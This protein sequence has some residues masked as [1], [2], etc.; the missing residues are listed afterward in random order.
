MPESARPKRL[1]QGHDWFTYRW[2]VAQAF[3]TIDRLQDLCLC[4]IGGPS[5]DSREDS[6][7]LMSSLALLLDDLQAELTTAQAAL[8]GAP[9]QRSFEMYWMGFEMD[10]TLK[11][12][13]AQTESVAASACDVFE[14]IRLHLTKIK[15][16]LKTLDQ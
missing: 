15:N 12:I 4:R 11:A 7:A 14:A 9:A 2:P 8:L 3:D 16:A 6:T 1:Y 5:T 10:L 13:Q